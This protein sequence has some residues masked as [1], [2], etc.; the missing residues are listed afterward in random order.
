[1]RDL[2]NGVNSHIAS[3]SES[4]ILTICHFYIPI[5][6]CVCPPPPPP[7]KKKHCLQLLLGLTI[8]PREIQ[9]NAYPTQFFFF[10][11]GGGGII[12]VF[13]FALQRNYYV[14]GCKRQ[15][16]DFHT[17]LYINYAFSLCS[18]KTIAITIETSTILFFKVSD[19]TKKKKVLVKKYSF[20]KKC[21]KREQ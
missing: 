15:G 7:P 14:C 16:Q 20:Q 1:M 19:R 12:I 21:G 8:V 4:E 13:F 2:N 5:V 10:F 3:V 18:M 9:N 6:H 17:A 11:W